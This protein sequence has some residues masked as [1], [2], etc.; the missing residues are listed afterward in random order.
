[1]KN[2][3]HIFLI[4]AA[5]LYGNAFAEEVAGP[6]SSSVTSDEQL[7]P[8]EVYIFPEIAPEVI[9]NGGYRFVG[10][11]GSTQAD[12]YEYLHNSVLFG[13]EIRTLFFPHRFHLDIDFRNEKD[14]EGDLS[15]AYKDNILLRGTSRA[16][17]HNLEN[18]RLIDLDPSNSILAYG[19]DRKDIGKD[20]GVD[21]RIDTMSLRLKPLEFAMHFFVEGRLVDR[22]GTMQQRYLGGAAYHTIPP[23]FGPGITRVSQKRDVDWKTKEYTVG[24]NSH[25]GPV[26]VEYSHTEK[27]FSAGDDRFFRYAYNAST[28][29]L[30]GTYSHN[31]VSDLKGSTDTVKLHTSYTGGLVAAATFSKTSRENEISRAKADYLI[32]AGDV[33]WVLSPQLAIFLK[34]RH[35]E[36][37]ID[38]SNVDTYGNSCSPSNQTGNSYKCDIVRSIS[39]LTDTVSGMVRYRPLT[40]LML[41]AGYTYESV[42]REHAEKWDLERSADK[43]TVFVSADL[44]LIKGLTLK[45]KYTHR[46]IDHPLNNV[47]PNHSDEGKISISWIPV[48]KVSALLSYS[49][50][51]EKRNDLEFPYTEEGNTRKVRRDS[52]LGSITVVVLKDLSVT[53]SYAYMHNKTEQDITYSYTEPDP[54]PPIYTDSRVRFTSTVN[55]YSLDAS[56]MPS[57]NINLNGGVQHVISK[58]NFYPSAANLLEPISVASFSALD[59]KETAFLAGGQYRLRGG[60]TVGMQYKYSAVNDVLNNSND[61]VKDGKAHIVSLTLSK[62]W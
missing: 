35:K 30:A 12:E 11:S 32:G 57:K 36:A 53:A 17:F 37:D 55:S 43:D 39:S 47:E 16:V 27:R 25:F 20:Y 8:D 58:G 26:E 4:L 2:I 40:G 51:K 1:M 34:Y 59:M 29:R 44:R 19:V 13:G 41:R 18:I 62:K 15:Y 48:P 23:F 38:N 7:N 24:A 21:A 50:I 3:Q 31:L 5:L 60:V 49:F 46:D 9:V 56:Y 54:T 22:S 28:E 45:A 52:L 61:D 14:F 33:T 6:E 10:P 42:R